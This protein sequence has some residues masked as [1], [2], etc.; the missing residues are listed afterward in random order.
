MSKYFIYFFLVRPIKIA[1]PVVPPSNDLV[2]EVV[3]ELF[4][5]ETTLD[6]NNWFQD[7]F[8]NR[9]SNNYPNSNYSEKTHQKY[10]QN[11]KNWVS[12]IN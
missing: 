12:S 5:F 1:L 4:V 2:E 7:Y 9:H 10:I 3:V 8:H 6:R 11:M